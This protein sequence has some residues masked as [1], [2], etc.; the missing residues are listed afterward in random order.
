MFVDDAPD[1]RQPETGAPPHGL[2][3]EEGIEDPRQDGR[4]HAAPIV[5]H[6]QPGVTARCKFPIA[7]ATCLRQVHGFQ[8]HAD[9][10]GPLGAGILDGMHGVG[11]EIHDHLV[12]LRRVHADRQG[13][14][15]LPGFQHHAGG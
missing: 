13:V 14:S 7:D 5:G 12:Q 15:G 4:L 10:P 8:R 11:H 3:R 9:A 2:G 1:D 6:A